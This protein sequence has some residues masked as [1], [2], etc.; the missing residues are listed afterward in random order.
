MR[1]TGTIGIDL[2]TSAIKGVLL[3]EKGE[4][5]ATAIRATE[6][7]R[8]VPG[9]VVFSSDRC[10][11]ILCGILQELAKSE[12][13]VRIG[14]VAI[15]GATGDTLLLNQDGHPLLPTIHWMD[16]RSAEDPGV[17]PPGM[18]GADIYQ[19]SGWPWFRMFPLAHLAWLQAHEAD[20]YRQA[21]RVGMNVTF[22]Y[23]RLCGAWVIDPS[24]ATTFYLQNQQ[25]QKWHQPYLHWLGLDPGQLPEIHSSGSCVGRISRAASLE[26]GL[27]EGCNVVLGSFDHPSAARG[28]GVVK[29]GELL[30]S[31][32][33][34][35]VGFYPLE[36]RAQA[37][38][39]DMLVDP[40][41]AGENGPWGAMF[42]LTEAGQKINGA[43][44]ISY[45][46]EP[47]ETKR[48]ALVE[49]DIWQS[50]RNGTEAQNAAVALI[51]KLVET[52]RERIAW[53]ANR[54]LVTERIV[55]VGGPSANAAIVE[56]FKDILAKPI[57][58]A[59]CSAHS[60]AVGA[61]LMAAESLS[62]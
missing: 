14:A 35:W 21:R 36:D 54:N 28:A 58:V 48:H 32:G 25:Q 9:E 51:R 61:A 7:E 19:T 43:L 3:S 13:S 31:L 38:S 12:P 62:P 47:E 11:E 33:S 16:T 15:S 26:T 22:Q 42:S 55:L 17:D 5:R 2:G 52:M 50:M 44:R 49:K 56:L 41:L 24:T 34:S 53:F 40:F 1:E 46:D 29:P 37:L 60:G 59:P 39:L 30:L 20:A 8:P 27:P 45:S 10:Y 4:I 23:F 6:L 18:T 57:Q